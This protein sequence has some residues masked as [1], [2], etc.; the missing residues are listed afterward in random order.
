M[1]AATGN[2][3]KIA[4]ALQAVLSRA[5]G[6]LQSA[7]FP[8]RCHQCGTLPR[9]WPAAPGGYP[10]LCAP[11]H[12]ALPWRPPAHAPV[13]SAHIARLYA[14]LEYAPPVAGWVRACKYAR[15]EALA[16]LLGALMA[17]A[18]HDAP[19]DAETLAT[20][21]PLHWRRHLWRG[22]NQS[23]LLAESWRA[24]F[25]AAERPAPPVRH[26][27]RRVRA[28]PRQARL[29]AEARRG[30]L[31]GA[32]TLAPGAEET[33]AGRTVLLVDD[34]LTTGATLN[35]CAAVLHAGGAARVE[36]LVLCVTEQAAITLAVTD[37]QAT[38]WAHAEPGGSP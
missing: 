19:P 29:D 25:T 13:L 16:P 31:R 11:C 5:G 37:Q 38:V 12:A 2:H 27:L 28:T 8:P 10:H 6:A 17:A 15:R 20:P 9:Q 18:T 23:A 4:A 21:V 24:H 36:A 35:E 26:L 7:V 14:P 3:G 32:I 34:V 1:H 22:F 33:I 30:N